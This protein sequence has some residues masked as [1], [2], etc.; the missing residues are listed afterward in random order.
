MNSTTDQN[1]FVYLIT[2]RTSTLHKIGFTSTSIEKRMA[3]LQTGS[4][5]ELELV[6][7][8]P[9]TQGHEAALHRKLAKYRKQGEWFRFPKIVV[10]ELQLLDPL[11]VEAIRL[12]DYNNE[13][14]CHPMQ[15]LIVAAE[16][17][18]GISTGQVQEIAQTIHSISEPY[19][20]TK[21][22]DIETGQ[23]RELVT[24]LRLMGLKG[25]EQKRFARIKKLKL[26][27][28]QSTA[29]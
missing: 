8:W 27:G 4:A 11:D 15:N 9:G 28:L 17:L 13:A 29:G 25:R 12:P 20:W 23:L 2:P 19:F 22:V 7:S 10:R 24:S 1:G 5:T 6:A 14:Q 3:Q 26:N 16:E 18:V 21:E